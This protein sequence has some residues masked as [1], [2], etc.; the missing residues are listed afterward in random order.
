VQ[1]IAE[2]GRKPIKMWTA[3]VPVEEAARQ[4]LRNIATL[5][6]IYKHIAVMP[7]VHLGKGATVGS[8]IPTRGAVIPAAVGV[9]IGCVDADT[10]F[11]SRTGWVPI[12]EYEP[13]Q[14]VMQYDPSTRTGTW[15]QPTKY[16]KQPC[17]W[18]YWFKTKYGVDQMLSPEHRVL[19]APHTKDGRYNRTEVRSAEEI[20]RLH[21]S[22][23][24]GFRGRFYTT[25]TPTVDSQIPLSDAAIRVMV[26][27]IADGHLERKSTTCVLRLR[28]QRKISRARALLRSADIAFTERVAPNGDA[29]FRFT[30]PWATKSYEAFWEASADQLAIIADECLHWD[31]NLSDRCFYTSVEAS[32]DFIQ[33]AMTSA[34][35]RSVKR[36]DCR[37]DQSEYRV[38]AHTNTQVGIAGSPKTPMTIV[39]SRDGFKYCFVVPSG[40]FVIRRGGNIAMTGNCGMVAART[41]ITAEDLPNLKK[42]RDDI[43]AAVPVGNDNSQKHNSTSG[44]AHAVTQAW[45]KW[46]KL[47]PGFDQIGAKYQ[48]IEGRRARAVEQLGT[49]GGGNHF[50]EVC[51]DQDG[52]VWVML[53]SGS[54]NIGNVIGQHFIEL[55]KNDMRVHFINLP[56]QDLAYLSEGTQHFNDYMLAVEW[57]Q[58]YAADNRAIMLTQVLGAVAKNSKRFRDNFPQEVVANCHHNYIRR[59]NHFG[60]NILV[61]RKGAV[62]AREGEMGIIP[63]SMG[64]R[65][66]IVRGKGN[67][68]S[69]TSCSHGAGRTMSRGD[70]KRRIS[71]EEHIA[72]TEGIECRKDLGVLDESPSAYK[73]IEAVIAAQ[74]DLLE[75][76]YVLRQIVCVKG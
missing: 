37:G 33:Y 74:S 58:R 11:L 69:F 68:D 24:L 57:A 1:V 4:Q 63:G 55:A 36:E 35:F 39:P 2:Q 70:A 56:D 46:E 40:F 30:A 76:V 34:G 16:I 48:K 19:F 23:V 42:L 25:F 15:V 8:V 20:Y 10:E 59:E 60:E 32:A 44:R 26:M 54:R 21:E 3:G 61:T 12:S 67:P 52:A 41:A 13:G 71:L 62:S 22:N 51:L 66:Y 9:D 47:K 31:G 18:F 45:A 5:P 64:T 6:F 73:D 27:I 49:L 53:H 29:T 28:K 38:F 75:V 50:I 65:S 72:A 17:E 43:E 14:W 7:D